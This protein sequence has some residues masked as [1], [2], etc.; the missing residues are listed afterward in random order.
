MII[1]EQKTN[2]SIALR[3]VPSVP[4][5]TR[6]AVRDTVLPVGGG[7]DGRSPIFVKKGTQVYFSAYSMHRREQF[8][9]EKTEEFILEIWDSLRPTWVSFII[10]LCK[11]SRLIVAGISPF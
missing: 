4:A 1:R 9:G 10:A 11:V 5:N 6:E 7:P 3:L 2:I 8:F